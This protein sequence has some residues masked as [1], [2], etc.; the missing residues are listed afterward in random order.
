[1]LALGIALAPL[2]GNLTPKLTSTHQTAARRHAT[3]YGAAHTSHVI[4][5]APRRPSA[6]GAC[7]RVSTHFCRHAACTGAVQRHG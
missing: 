3:R 1:M 4:G 2:L 7:G 5:A 6:G